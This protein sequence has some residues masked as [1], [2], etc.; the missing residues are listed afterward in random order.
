MVDNCTREEE[1]EFENRSVISWSS[2]Y[3]NGNDE[4][5]EKLDKAVEFDKLVSLQPTRF[6]NVVT[7]YVFFTDIFLI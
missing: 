6:L 2:W 7:W 5:V 4:D 1:N 3:K